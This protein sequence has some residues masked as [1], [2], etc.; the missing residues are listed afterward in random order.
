MA[1]QKSSSSPVASPASASTIHRE[2][3]AP[4]EAD[5]ANGTSLTVEWG[6]ITAELM[7]NY[8]TSTCISLSS[9]PIMQ[10]FMQINIPRIG[11]ANPHVL[12]MVLGISALHM[13]RFNP[14]RDSYYLDHANRHYQAGLWIATSLLQNLNEENCHGLYLFSSQCTLFTLARGPTPGD[15]LLF[16]DNGLAEW[17]T[18]FRGAHPVL[19]SYGDIIRNGPLAPMIQDGIQSLTRA[20]VDMPASETDQLTILRSMVESHPSS[21]EELRTLNA[22]LDELAVLFSSR[23]SI[24]GRKAQVETRSIG[25]WLYRVSG[26]FTTLLQQQHP[27]ALTILHTPVFP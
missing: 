25:I 15:F 1:I 17:M 5:T 16:S 24:E 2:L 27:V 9:N 21:S 13:A 22:A 6:P 8:I 18:L 12:H 4:S 20:R 26:T 10:T 7:H 3:S 11:F 19:E 23:Y 14:N